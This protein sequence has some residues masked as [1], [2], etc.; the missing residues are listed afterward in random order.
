MKKMLATLALAT[1]LAALDGFEIRTDFDFTVAI[2]YI[3]F[4]IATIIRVFGR[5]TRT[6]AGATWR[7]AGCLGWLFIAF[8][9]ACLNRRW[10][11]DIHFT[12]CF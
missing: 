9:L 7:T 4:A 3:E 2:T 10:L 6:T 8:A 11:G 12:W 5:T 1:A